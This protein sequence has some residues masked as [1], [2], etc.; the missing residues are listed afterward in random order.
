MKVTKVKNG[1]KYGPGE[2]A[3][4]NEKKQFWNEL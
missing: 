4:Q 2:K 1:G 3:T